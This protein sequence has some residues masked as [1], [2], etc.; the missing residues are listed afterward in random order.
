VKAAKGSPDGNGVRTNDV[1]IPFALTNATSISTAADCTLQAAM[2]ARVVTAS[3]AA[4]TNSAC[5][6]PAASEVPSVAAPSADLDC[7]G[8]NGS[9]DPTLAVFVGPTVAFATPCTTGTRAC[10]DG[11]VRRPYAT[12]LEAVQNLGSR[13][14]IYVADGTYSGAGARIEID[15]GGGA[16]LGLFGGYSGQS[17]FISRSGA[18]APSITGESQNTPSAKVFRFAT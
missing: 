8:M 16:F 10:S 13:R 15:K 2:Y 3:G 9:W 1:G 18:F 11:A 14:A 17:G 12:L 4:P 5:G 6:A 7:D